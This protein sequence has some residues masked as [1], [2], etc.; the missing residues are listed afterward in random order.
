MQLLV[1]CRVMKKHKTKDYHQC[2]SLGEVFWAD[3]EMS[4]S[5]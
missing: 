3:D 2:S 5:T 1:V 4:S